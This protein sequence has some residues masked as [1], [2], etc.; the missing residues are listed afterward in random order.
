MP[1]S[2]FR[3]WSLPPVVTLGLVLLAI[4]YVRGWRIVRRADPSLLPAW[5]AGA[6][7]SGLG[8]IWIALASPL[9]ALNDLL[10]TAHMLQHMLLMMV[11]PPLML[12]GV[13]LVPIVRGLPAVVARKR[14]GSFLISSGMQRI[15]RVF[16]NP[17]S[18]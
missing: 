11:A 10:L 12:L 15:G 17:I 13:P 6:F 3:S 18:G 14:V 5:R 16:A 2:L 8:F 1:A 4:V 7:L 9:D